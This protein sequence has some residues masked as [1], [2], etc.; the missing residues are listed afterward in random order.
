MVLSISIT[1]IIVTTCLQATE[2]ATAS[3]AA[4]YDY[5]CQPWYYY[6]PTNGQCTCKTKTTDHTSHYKVGCS[7]HGAIIALGFCTTHEEGNGTFLVQC[8]YFQ[9]NGL[10]LT[11]DGYTLP[12]NIS[13]LNDYMC[14]PM[15]RMNKLCADCI[16]HFGPS[17]TSLGYECS[18]CTGRR[19]GVPLY[20]L[21]ELGP[22]TMLYFI[23]VVFH[24]SVT[25]APM[26][27]YIMCSQA[28]IYAL[29]YDRTT[30]VRAIVL[31][32]NKHTSA[33]VKVIIA[34][35]GIWNLDFIRYLVPPFCVSE[36]LKLIH[37]ASLGYI[38]AFYPLLLI[39]LTWVC[40]ELHGRNFKPLV[41]LW[42]PLHKC[43]FI[44]RKGCDLKCDMIGIFASFFFLSYSKLVYQSVMLISCQTMTNKNGNNQQ[45]SMV[46]PSIYCLST[47]HLMFA[48]PAWFT[49]ISCVIIPSLLFL[50][51]STKS[52]RRCLS[53]CRL[54][55]QCQAKLS[56]FMEKYYSCCRD[57]LNGGRDMRVFAGFYFIL[58]V[59]IS[60]YYSLQLQ[61]ISFSFW[62]YQTIIFSS[63]ALLIAFVKPYKKTYMNILDTLQLAWMTLLCLLLS[64]EHTEPILLFVLCLV[65]AVGFASY[66]T[67]KLTKRLRRQVTGFLNQTCCRWKVANPCHAQELSNSE[68]LIEPT[69]TVVDV[70]NYMYDSIN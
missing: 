48:I 51:Y 14:G 57:G 24:I 21:V 19:Y 46:D 30:P 67:V 28:I 54:S 39:F 32:Q 59:L 50:L 10:N 4:Q 1:C 62:T 31:S 66:N 42:R 65:P 70:P 11:S 36:T 55:G 61:Q 44:L 29:I 43:T 40:I 47:Q 6:N 7:K 18:N 49:L 60:L 23:I 41:V 27:G 38:S 37:I 22:I 9:P 8:P 26:T 33:A 15:K 5:L 53:K 45:V 20:L 68:P 56:I 63:A 12:Y 58:R 35:Y 2:I 52:F 13:E 17:Y 16:D 25:S 34:L 3:S 69:S 64:Q